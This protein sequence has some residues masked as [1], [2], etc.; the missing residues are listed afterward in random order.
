MYL[1]GIDSVSFNDKTGEIYVA[2]NPRLTGAVFSGQYVK[3]SLFE[4]N[5][6][7]SNVAKLLHCWLCSNIRLGQ[8]LG[9]GNGAMLDT[10]AP[11]IW[12]KAWEGFSTSSKSKKRNLLREALIEIADKTRNLRGGYG[13][14]IDQT[15]SGLVLVSRPKELPL[16]ESKHNMTPSEFHTVKNR[17]AY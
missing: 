15:N 4:R 9:H 5:E 2:A 14:A 11:H 8:S 1:V 13:W 12:G 16:L 17:V 6:L 7:E 10:L 3:V